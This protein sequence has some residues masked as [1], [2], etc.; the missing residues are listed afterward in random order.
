[1][2][3]LLACLLFAM[4]LPYLA[5][6]PV[7][8]AMAKQGGYDNAYPRS[9]QAQLTGFGARALA[10]H[11][12]AFESLLIFAVA[13][14]TVIARDKVDDTVGLL[15]LVHV[16]ARCAYHLLYL[17]DKSTLRSLSWFVAII[18]AFSIFAR[19]F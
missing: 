14:L 6:V 16:L 10:A 3:M 4:L 19:A 11:Q 18:A 7:A 12:N 9:Q 13:A 1:M 8:M 2:T 5:K 17:L 15:A